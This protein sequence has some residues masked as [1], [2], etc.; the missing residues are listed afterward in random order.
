M[1]SSENLNEKPD[2]ISEKNKTFDN[3]FKLKSKNWN[4][5]G[6]LKTRKMKLCI[7]YIWEKYLK[8]KKIKKLKIKKKT[9]LKLEFKKN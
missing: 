7:K 4:F 5:D 8:I 3:I 6:K 9:N 2:C 1:K